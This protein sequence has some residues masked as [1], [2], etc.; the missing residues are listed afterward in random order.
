[1]EVEQ[2]ERFLGVASNS[3]IYFC[4]VRV[5]LRKVLAKSDCKEKTIL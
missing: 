5:G 3:R 1:M 4:I 2:F